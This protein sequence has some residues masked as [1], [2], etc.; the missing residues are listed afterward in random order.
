VYVAVIGGPLMTLPQ[1]YSIWMEH[2]KGV[3]I[4]SWTGYMLT[5]VIWLVYGLKHREWPI[6]ILQLTWIALDL[7]VIVGLVLLK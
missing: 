4:V 2:Q 3:S 6:I 7:G 5:G 1:I